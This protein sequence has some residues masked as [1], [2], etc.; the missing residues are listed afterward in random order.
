MG[1]MDGKGKRKWTED[2]KGKGNGRVTATGEGKGKGKG[3]GN[4]KDI[5]KQT[6]GGDDISRA[7]A[8]Q[9]QT[10]MVKADSDSKG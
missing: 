3:N 5:V 6:P 10:E 2:R 9:L 8:L 1:T 4:G 7:I